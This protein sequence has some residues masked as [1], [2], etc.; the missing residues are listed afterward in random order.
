MA[1]F[2][3]LGRFTVAVGSAV[4][5]AEGVEDVVESPVENHPLL[6]SSAS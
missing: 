6:T 2:P 3:F 4:E 1:A 5:A